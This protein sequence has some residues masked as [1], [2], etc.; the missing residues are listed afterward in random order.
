MNLFTGDFEN[1]CYDPM[2]IN[3]FTSPKT[4][5]PSMKVHTVKLNITFFNVLTCEN[6]FKFIPVWFLQLQYT[7]LANM[8]TQLV[9]L[10][11]KKCVLRGLRNSLE[12]LL[13]LIEQLQSHIRYVERY[14]LGSNESVLL[15]W[16]E[17]LFKNHMQQIQQLSIILIGTSVIDMFGTL[18]T[19][20]LCYFNR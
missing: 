7:L 17:R 9:F 11:L 19:L 14:E 20:L 18:R 2:C 3:L 1:F 8:L 4:A 5:V 6:I 16:P 13:L 10:V 12:W 15:M